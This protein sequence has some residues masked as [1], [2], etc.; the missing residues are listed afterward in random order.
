MIIKNKTALVTG[1]A[2][3]VG[4]VIAV[5][6][7]KRGG[8]VM[9]HYHR[10]KIDALAT[11]KLLRSYG[12]RADSVKANLASKQ[13]AENMVRTTIK[14]FGAL[15][16]LVNSASRYV[17]TPFGNINESDWDSHLDA[18]LKSIFFASQA[19][20]KIMLKRRRGK[21]INIIDSDIHQPYLNYTPYLV[22]KSGLVGLTVCLAKELAPNIQVN[23]ISPGPVMLP[24]EWG[25]KI[26]KAIIK[27]TPLRRIGVPEDI[28]NAVIFCV[29]GTDFMTGAVI[30]IDGGQHIE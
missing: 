1:S 6:L 19:A 27:V 20:S 23:G 21:I 5:E 10:S 25:A 4:K 30:P 3:R 12:V 29:E 8:N 11:V 17:K 18:N 14:K 2:R 16:I 22:S 28:A 15:D 7:A 26:R 9:V 24:K 13:E